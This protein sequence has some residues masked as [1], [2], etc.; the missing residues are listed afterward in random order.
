MKLMTINATSIKVTNARLY[1]AISSDRESCRV[2]EFVDGFV[3]TCLSQLVTPYISCQIMGLNPFLGL[4][5]GIGFGMLLRLVVRF[6][7]RSMVRA[8]Q[9]SMS[10]RILRDFKLL[11]TNK[12]IDPCPGTSTT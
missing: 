10:L 12:D 6:L 5:M 3:I 11:V 8:L 7:F 4:G 1:V 2:A 9:V